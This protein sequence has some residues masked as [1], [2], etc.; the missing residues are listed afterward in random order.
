MLWLLLLPDIW[1]AVKLMIRVESDDCVPLLLL[2]FLLKMKRKVFYIFNEQNFIR[3]LSWVLKEVLSKKETHAALKR[4]FPFCYWCKRHELFVPCFCQ[5]TVFGVRRSTF[6][7]IYSLLSFVESSP[8]VS[9]RTLLF[10]SFLSFLTK[11]REP[12]PSFKEV[13][14]VSRQRLV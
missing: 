4:I 9:K 12:L 6:L 3:S 5:K 7:S 2:W 1:E 8:R 13:S 14:R 11:D 10:F